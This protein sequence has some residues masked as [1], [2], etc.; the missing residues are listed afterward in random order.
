MLEAIELETAPSP[1]IAIIWLH[2]LGTDGSDFVPMV[3]QFQAAG[4]PPIRFI[5]PHAPMMPVTVNNGFVMRAWYDILGADL[6]RREDE[7]GVR[8]SQTAIEELI[9]AQLARGIASERILL[10]GFSQGCAMVL[11][12]GL[13]YP[14]RLAG[15]L[16]LSGYLPLSDAVEA[17]R[18]P[19]NQ[20]TP[21]FMAHGTM[22]PVV[23]IDRAIAARTTLEELGYAVDWRDYPMPHAVC[24]QEI[25]DIG[26]W[27]MRVLS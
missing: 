6:T 3:G 24:P 13:R 7:A 18:N 17:E 4:C 12:T 10:A 8:A 20:D 11:Q 14:Q 5:F 22:D 2:G 1:A 19:A 9:A 25:G 23:P 15:L 26:A 16:C 21:I 27:M